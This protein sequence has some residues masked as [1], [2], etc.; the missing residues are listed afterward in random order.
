MLKYALHISG[1][2]L[3]LNAV[4]R[5]PIFLFL[6]CRCTVSTVF[7]GYAVLRTISSIATK[8][9]HPAFSRFSLA[10]VFAI[11]FVIGSCLLDQFGS[12][13]G[14]YLNA[15]FDYFLIQP[16]FESYYLLCYLLQFASNCRLVEFILTAFLAKVCSEKV[17]FKIF[18]SSFASR[19]AVLLFYMLS[20]PAKVFSL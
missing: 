8:L 9:G 14:H 4:H 11:V 1:I 17:S 2:A 6:E 18:S 12:A 15:Y 19:A 5:Y 7:E 10:F 16:V 13:D 3:R 20:I